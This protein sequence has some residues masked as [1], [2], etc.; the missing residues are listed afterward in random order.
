ML[1]RGTRNK[2]GNFHFKMSEM[3]GSPERMSR[4]S[5]FHNIIHRHAEA[6]IFVLFNIKDLQHAV[7]RIFFENVYQR[8]GQDVVI[9][10]DMEPWRNPYFFAYRMMMDAF[11]DTQLDRPG[12]IPFDQPV[13]F[14]F[15]DRAEKSQILAAWDEY[16]GN[17]PEEKRKL[18][19]AAPRFENDEAFLP[20]QA[21]DFRAWWLRKW[22][23]ENGY[24]KVNDGK[25]EFS[26]QYLPMSG[27][28][29]TVDEE[30]ITN[31][32]KDIAQ[33]SLPDGVFARDKGPAEQV[34]PEPML[35][36]LFR[37]LMGKNKPK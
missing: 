29:I 3:A 16:I 34:D 7:D 21:A 27:I 32:L 37:S 24:D 19:G 23:V 2:Y 26:T 1:P 31:R 36:K 20:L 11:H 14:Y 4:V 5:G 25:Y 12:V 8:V 17:M 6:L 33:S 9:V 30:Q 13:D 35:L 18:F 22:A 10:A 15:D 28:R